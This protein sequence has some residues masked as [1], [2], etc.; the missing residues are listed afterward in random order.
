MKSVK[1]HL[2]LSNHMNAFQNKMNDAER[3]I[4]TG[5]NAQTPKRMQLWKKHII[6]IALCEI[7]YE[8]HY[9]YSFMSIKSSRRNVHIQQQ[10]TQKRRPKPCRVN[11][12]QVTRWLFFRSVRSQSG[13]KSLARIGDASWVE[14]T[15]EKEKR[16]LFLE[17]E[18]AAESE[19]SEET[20]KKKKFKP[21]PS[22]MRDAAATFGVRLYDRGGGLV[23]RTRASRSCEY[24]FSGKPNIKGNCNNFPSRPIVTNSDILLLQQSLPAYAALCP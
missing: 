18:D 19:V 8:S 2:W 7:L 5:L 16:S 15:K 22:A 9:E 21:P 13:R 4:N 23:K 6:I 14:N 12:M 3:Q 1:V 17:T 10:Q 24:T 11:A 20:R